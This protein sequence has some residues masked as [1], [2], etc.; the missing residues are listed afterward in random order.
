MVI[1]GDAS[2]MDGEWIA[3]ETARLRKRFER[4]KAELRELAKADGLLKD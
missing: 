1:L 4:V 3:R 2:G